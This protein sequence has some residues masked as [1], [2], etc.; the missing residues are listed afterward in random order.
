M[1]RGIFRVSVSH[2]VSADMKRSREGSP[3][4]HRQG[5]TGTAFRR[6]PRSSELPALLVEEVE[7]VP[8]RPE[9]LSEF[10]MIR[11]LGFE[12]ATSSAT[13]SPV[14]GRSADYFLSPE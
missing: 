12:T 4:F 14:S 11:T 8:A 3:R 2:H 9:P 10:G 7:L 6:S 13:H 1:G 5:A